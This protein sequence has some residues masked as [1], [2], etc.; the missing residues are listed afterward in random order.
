MCPLT[1]GAPLMR[2]LY[3]L[4][5]ELRWLEVRMPTGSLLVCSDEFQIFS[6]CTKIWSEVRGVPS[7]W[8]TSNSKNCPGAE[9]GGEKRGPVGVS[10]WRQ[11]SPPTPASSDPGDAEVTASAVPGP[12][13][14]TG[15]GQGWETGKDVLESLSPGRAGPRPLVA[16]LRP[17]PN[18]APSGDVQGV[19]VSGGT[20]AH[21]LGKQTL[22]PAPHCPA[23][24]WGRC[25]GP[26][27]L[28]V[29]HHSDVR[30]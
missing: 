29:V 16:S 7:L 26:T 12:A 11:Q 30:G 25:V 9:A 6:S 21:V 23:A 8:Y 5:Q 2:V 1:P 10:G 19:P 14:G 17:G 22:G 28:V 24:A 4:A 20:Q 18:W 13:E 3:A 27:H 15:S